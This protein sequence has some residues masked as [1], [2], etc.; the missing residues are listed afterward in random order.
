[1]VVEPTAQAAGQF[2]AQLVRIM[3]CESVAQRGRCAVALAGGTT[4]RSLYQLLAAEATA[5]AVPWWDCDI[6]FGDERDVPHDDI[7]SNYR[8]AQRSLLDHVPIDPQRVHPMP[9]DAEDLQAAAERYEQKI[10]SSLP[11][12]PG[13]LPQFDLILLGMG[14]DGHT[15]SLFPGTELLNETRR[16]V[17]SQYVPV[18]GRNRMTFTFPLINA[19]R[20]VLLLVTGDD[21]APAIAGLLGEDAPARQRLPVA[22]VHPSDGKL[23]I[24]LD[25]AAAR[26]SHAGSV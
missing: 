2:A 22:R 8:T 11:A 15:A 1:V 25:A 4:P 9:A 21:K 18:L 6:F 10:R 24:V 20:N 19:A 26:A 14:A 7:D 17:A 13:G 12:G 5:G 3:M 16:L 23:I